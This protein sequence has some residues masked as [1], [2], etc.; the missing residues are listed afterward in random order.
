V[1][2]KSCVAIAK[3]RRRLQR[4]PN[5][6]IIY[7]DETHLRVGEAPRDTLVAPGESQYLVVDDNNRYAPRYDMICFVYGGGVFPAIVYT[8]K[9]RK[10]LKVNGI[11]KKM[12]NDYILNQLSVHVGAKDHYPWYIV[13][14]KSNI[15]N[16]AEIKESFEDGMVHEIKEVIFLPTQAAKRMSPLDNGIFGIWKQRCRN[17]GKIAK[18]N[19]V[20]IMIQEW[21][22]IS[23][24]EIQSAYRHCGLTSSRDPYFDCHDPSSH[25]HTKE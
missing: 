3:L 17:H 8:P 20:S 13:C 16:A 25:T 22:K 10:R 1:S 23:V 4:I 5:T 12:L 19:I 18:A 6:D 9:D 14:D 21:E 11:T 24:D 7:F 2:N 15:H